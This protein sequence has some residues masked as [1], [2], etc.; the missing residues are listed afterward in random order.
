MTRAGS[1]NTAGENQSAPDS[2]RQ[3]QNPFVRRVSRSSQFLESKPCERNWKLNS[4]RI[5]ASDCQWKN[6]NFQSFR[7]S[8]SEDL[9]D[10]LQ[11][12]CNGKTA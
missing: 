12:A 4:H 2:R 5:L 11:E 1:S 9:I 7:V 3:S 10:A 8:N 6:S